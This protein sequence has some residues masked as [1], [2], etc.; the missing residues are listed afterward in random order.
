[1]VKVLV[2]ER[3]PRLAQLYREELE[4][5]GFGVCVKTDLDSALAQLRSQPAHVMVTDMASM[6]ECPEVWVPLIREVYTGPVLALSALGQRPCTGPGVST[7][8][9]I[10]DLTP[11]IQSIRGRT[12]S[13]MW[14]ATLTGHC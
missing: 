12:A 14:D 11:L 6:G 1:M 8:P 2:V 5:A 7:M 9:K 10:S 3:D 13:A 4:E